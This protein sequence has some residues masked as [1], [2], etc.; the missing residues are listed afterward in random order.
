VA[1]EPTCACDVSSK[2]ASLRRDR[3][4]MRLQT[5]P[6]TLPIGA[7]AMLALCICLTK[8]TAAQRG[9]CVNFTRCALLWGIGS[10]FTAGQELVAVVRVAASTGCIRKRACGATGFSGVFLCVTCTEAGSFRGDARNARRSCGQRLAECNGCSRDWTVNVH[11]KLASTGVPNE[12]SARPIQHQKRRS[13]HLG[14]RP[15]RECGT[16]TPQ[17]RCRR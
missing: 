11:G 4:L 1:L 12:C 3:R 9:A 15:C 2:H 17:Y 7:A 13:S 16:R 5:N 8:R 14:M 6:A 10:A